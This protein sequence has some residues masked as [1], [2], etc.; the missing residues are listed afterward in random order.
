MIFEAF[1]HICSPKKSFLKDSNM[2]ESPKSHFWKIQTGLPLQRLRLIKRIP[3][4]R[5]VLQPFGKPSED[6]VL[7]SEAFVVIDDVMVLPIDENH[8]RLAAEE[9]QRGVHLDALADGDVRVC[10][11]VDEEQRGVHLVGVVERAVVHE[12]FLVGPRVTVCA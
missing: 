1:Q 2:L 3:P 7:P 12:Q 6:G 11:A 5:V 4:Q 8:R 9:L 10:C